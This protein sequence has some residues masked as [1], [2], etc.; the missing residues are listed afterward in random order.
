M[1][2]GDWGFNK[3]F[4]GRDPRLAQA[5]GRVWDALQ[6]MEDESHSGL[7]VVYVECLRLR[8]SVRYRAWRCWDGFAILEDR[9]LGNY[10]VR[11]VREW[12]DGEVGWSLITV[13]SNGVPI[14][15]IIARVRS[16]ARRRTRRLMRMGW[17]P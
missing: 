11:R 15:E 13:V 17:G 16:I 3:V 9:E 8:Y 5:E 14:D 1:V 2:I 4:P 7:V 12:A 6:R 10:W